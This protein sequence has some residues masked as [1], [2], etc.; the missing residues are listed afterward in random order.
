M[1]YTEAKQKYATL[2]INTE[3]VLNKMKEVNVSVHCWQ[4]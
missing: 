4:F 2:G 3:E 1:S